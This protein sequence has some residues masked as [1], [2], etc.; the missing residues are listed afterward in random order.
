[1]D[2]RLQEMTTLKEFALT[3]ETWQRG[4]S[5][6]RNT[7]GCDCSIDL[8]S[9]V[10]AGSFSRAVSFTGTFNSSPRDLTRDLFT[11]TC[12]PLE[13]TMLAQRWWWWNLHNSRKLVMNWNWQKSFSYLAG[14]EGIRYNGGELIV[15]E[16]L[17]WVQANFHH[18]T[19]Q[20]PCLQTYPGWE[21]AWRV[22]EKQEICCQKSINYVLDSILHVVC[23]GQ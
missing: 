22:E 4:F 21:W 8:I 10:M 12:T 17:R 5:S 6:S 9:E 3:C 7:L 16:H 1:M 20:I 14:E 11:I 13:W 19:T 15:V 2:L 23:Y 18:L